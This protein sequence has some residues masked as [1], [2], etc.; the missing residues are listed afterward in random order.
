MVIVPAGAEDNYIDAIYE[1]GDNLPEEEFDEWDDTDEDLNSPAFDP[2]LHLDPIIERRINGELSSNGGDGD[3]DS[4]DFGFSRSGSER[5]LDTLENSYFSNFDGNFD[6]NNQSTGVTSDDV[7]N[8]NTRDAYF[9]FGPG[10]DDVDDLMTAP[11][12]ITDNND[13]ATTAGI[14]FSPSITEYI[15]TIRPFPYGKIK[16]KIQRSNV[17]KRK[18]RH[19]DNGKYF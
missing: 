8:S 5:M 16:K 14:K 4:S 18:S 12:A 1:Y 15:N 11:I 17:G 13:G 7:V 2:D 19:L 9:F 10:G 6:D 3:L